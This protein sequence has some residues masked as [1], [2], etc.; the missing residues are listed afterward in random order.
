MFFYFEYTYKPNVGLSSALCRVLH[1]SLFDKTMVPKSIFTYY[2]I[3]MFIL[4]RIVR[5]I[6]FVPGIFIAALLV[7]A[8]VNYRQRSRTWIACLICAC[9]FY[10]VSIPATAHLALGLLEP[11]AAVPS[12]TGC[13]VM[14]VLCGGMIQ[15]TAD[16]SGTGSPAPN[17]ALRIIDAL[18]LYRVKQMPILLSGGTVFSSKAESPVAKRFLVDMGVPAGDIFIET[19][20]RDTAE[21]AVYVKKWMRGHNKKHALLVTSAFH[22]RRA[23]MLFNHE[24]IAFTAWP[25][26]RLAEYPA[27]GSFLDFCASS[28]ALDKNKVV[29]KECAAI[30]YY[31]LIFYLGEKHAAE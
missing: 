4:S 14:V 2:R 9:V 29:L 30:M 24:Q 28:D 31:A 25:A 26:G 27:A 13:D 18:R 21:N 19:E 8:L 1:K 3:K 5:S 20:S 17:T 12:F 22:V 16:C 10:L 7:I 15:G 11:P 23:A 6:L